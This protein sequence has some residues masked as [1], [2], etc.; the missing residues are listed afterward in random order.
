AVRWALARR[1]LI[2]GIVRRTFVVA[3]RHG[4]GTLI[5]EPDHR[6]GVVRLLARLERF[7]DALR[8]FLA[9]PQPGAQV[10]ARQLDTR[11][12]AEWGRRLIGKGFL[13]EAAEDRRRDLAAGVA[14]AHRRR[15]VVAHENAHD[16]VGRIADEPGVLFL[17]RRAGLAGE[18]TVE[19]LERRGG[20]A[21]DDAFEH[22]GHLI[23]RVR[24]HDLHT[25]VGNFWLFLAVTRLGFA[26]FAPALVMPPHGAAPAVL[27]AVDQR[28]AHLMPAVGDGAVAC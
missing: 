22:G 27:D 9:R 28:G 16:H 12:D 18:R 10:H 11:R 1:R 19:R 8:I 2:I 21:L 26:A 5:R 25:V 23:G 15:R 3:A 7:N 17:V 20:A 24:V 14:F 13:H 4:A 6:V